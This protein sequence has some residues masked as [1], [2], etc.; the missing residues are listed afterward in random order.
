MR[1]VTLAVRLGGLARNGTELR[2]SFSHSGTSCVHQNTVTLVEM[3]LLRS[4]VLFA[5][6]HAYYYGTG[7]CVA[8]NKLY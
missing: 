1:D 7:C 2:S 4:L 3:L 5:V 8:Y 6:L